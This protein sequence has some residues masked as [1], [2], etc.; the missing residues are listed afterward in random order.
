MNRL[1]KKCMM[2]SMG[3]HLLLI[4]VLFVGPAF[5]SKPSEQMDPII[6]LENFTVTDGKTGGGGNPTVTEPPAAAPPQPEPPQAASTPPPVKEPEP[7]PPKAAPEPEP[8][9][10]QPRE[11]AKAPEP[12]PVKVAPVKDPDAIPEVTKKP[13]KKPTK[14]APKMAFTPVDKSKSKTTAKT[15]DTKPKQEFTLKQVSGRKVTPS[16]TSNTSSQVAA[17]TRRAN[18]SGEV[19]RNI[20]RLSTAIGRSAAT[21]TSVEMPGPGGEAFVNYGQLVKERY[22]GAWRDPSDVADSNANVKVQVVV[23][24]TGSV[25]SARILSRSGVSAMDKSVQ[26]VLDRIRTI[27]EPFPAGSKDRQRTFII[28]FNLKTRRLNG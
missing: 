17:D 26:S 28:N 7:E 25:E 23:D 11:E 14:E 19:A 13:E 6:T 12:E 18:L 27:G 10:P 22:E 4:L 21:G 20:G 24:R 16:T 3:L 9:K 15:T 1:V 5:F 2:A 8:P